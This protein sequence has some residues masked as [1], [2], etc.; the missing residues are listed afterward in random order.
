MAENVPKS[1]LKRRKFPVEE[2]LTSKKSPRET[3]PPGAAGTV[4]SA[5]SGS[6][7]TRNGSP[8][9]AAARRSCRPP[10]PAAESPWALALS[11]LEGLQ[12][13][14]V[15]DLP[16]PSAAKPSSDLDGWRWRDL[17]EEVNPFPQSSSLIPSSL[18]FVQ[19]DLHT[20]PAAASSSAFTRRSASPQT[21]TAPPLLSSQRAA[22]PRRTEGGRSEGSAGE[23]QQRHG[24][25]EE[26]R[27]CPM[28]LQDFPSGAGLLCLQVLSD[29]P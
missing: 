22:P 24:G 21:E 23:E 7:G 19:Q 18:S 26:L 2:K 4:G 17:C 6:S 13:G 1:K 11:H 27:S 8:P 15:P 5:E 14:W 25:K 16:P 28:C 20:K 12:G 9:P 10:A 29:G 3:T